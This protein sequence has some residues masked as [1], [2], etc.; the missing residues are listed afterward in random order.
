M[1]EP[2]RKIINKIV[3]I[4]DVY[5]EIDEYKCNHYS[6]ISWADLVSD[7]LRKKLFSEL[8]KIKLRNAIETLEYIE[9]QI[10]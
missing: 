2:V 1:I 5:H 9:S 7:E 4:D 3:E 10:S 6:H 8:D